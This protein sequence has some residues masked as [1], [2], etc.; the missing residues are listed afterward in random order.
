MFFMFVF[1]D[2]GCRVWGLGIRDIKEKGRKN[3]EG[4]VTFFKY[5]KK[6]HTEKCWKK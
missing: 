2:M 6:R 3:L 1:G 5:F 4:Y